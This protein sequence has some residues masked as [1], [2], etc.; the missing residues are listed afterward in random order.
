MTSHI[1]LGK[2][3]LSRLAAGKVALRVAAKGAFL[4]MMALMI[5]TYARAVSQS[6]PVQPEPLPPYIYS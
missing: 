4:L 6:A 3:V 1:A 5:V 2:A